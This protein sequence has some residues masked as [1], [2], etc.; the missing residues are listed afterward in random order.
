MKKLLILFASIIILGLSPSPSAATVHVGN[1]LFT[2]HHVHVIKGHFFVLYGVIPKQD[3]EV[4]AKA[5]S[6][7]E[8]MHKDK[9]KHDLLKIKE[10]VE[11]GDRRET[12]KS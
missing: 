9:N 12:K 11:N 1:K 7:L 3:K 10:E 6:I 8:E 2:D 4:I 5:A